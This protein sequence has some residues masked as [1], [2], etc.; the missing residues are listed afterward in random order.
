MALAWAVVAR[1]CSNFLSKT[2]ANPP[3]KIRGD[4]P[5]EKNPWKKLRRRMTPAT[6]GPPPTSWC[7]SASRFLMP[8]LAGAL[9]ESHCHTRVGHPVRSCSPASKWPRRCFSISR[10]CSPCASQ[11]QDPLRGHHLLFF[12]LSLVILMFS[13]SFEWLVL[14]FIVRGLKEFGRNRR[15]SPP[16]TDL[17]SDD[18]KAGDVRSVLLA[19]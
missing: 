12:M 3:E 15:A 2:T 5:P 17:A 1:S 18:C 11:H 10:I 7:A 9:Y 13:R 6:R 4:P 16:L 14:A 19:S 8:S